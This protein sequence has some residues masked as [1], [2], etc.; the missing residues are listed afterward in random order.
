MRAYPRYL[1]RYPISDMKNPHPIRFR[2][3]IFR[4]LGSY[5]TDHS[6]FIC[7]CA[8]FSP[9]QILAPLPGWVNG[10]LVRTKEFS[11]VSLCRRRNQGPNC[12]NEHISELR[13]YLPSEKPS[14]RDF[15]IEVLTKI[16][17][18]VTENAYFVFCNY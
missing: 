5:N 18:R 10:F 1:P 17:F 9:D 12:L 8:K 13:T 14:K 4:T 15:L 6:L 2:Y 7:F 3:P 16:F 11:F